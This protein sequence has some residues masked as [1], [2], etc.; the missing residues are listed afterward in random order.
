[1]ATYTII[2]LADGISHNVVVIS[3]SGTCHTMRGFETEADA[4]EWIAHD[5]ELDGP[6]DIC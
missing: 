4:E 1:M 2:P 5:K 6:V 3:D